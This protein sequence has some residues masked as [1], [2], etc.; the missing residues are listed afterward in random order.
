MAESADVQDVKDG[1]TKNKRDRDMRQDGY[2]GLKLGELR[3]AVEYAADAAGE[4]LTDFCKRA[5]EREINGNPR[6]RLT[7]AIR[8][9]SI[10][11][12]IVEV[13]VKELDQDQVK[14]LREKAEEIR[15]LTDLPSAASLRSATDRSESAHGFV[16]RSA[17]A[18]GMSVEDWLKAESKKNQASI[19]QSDRA[20]T[21]KKPEAEVLP[22]VA[23]RRF[24][25]FRPEEEKPEKQVE[26]AKAE[27][28]TPAVPAKSGRRF[29]FSGRD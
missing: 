14:E 11:K 1:T 27:P 7:A 5:I 9:L 23:R 4:S 12:R 6:T 28:V 22:P 20:D 2:V 3:Q 29:R 18:A 15:A 13:A 10:T 8:S 17:E 21:G 26:H 25:F 19:A 24:H 16:E